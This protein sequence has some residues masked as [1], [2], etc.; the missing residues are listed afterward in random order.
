ML[1]VADRPHCHDPN[2]LLDHSIC[3]S[4]RRCIQRAVCTNGGTKGSKE[5]DRRKKPGGGESFE[6]TKNQETEILSQF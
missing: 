3:K 4:D 5:K 6:K 2:I 1:Y